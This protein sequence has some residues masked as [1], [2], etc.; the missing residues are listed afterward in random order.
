MG[1]APTKIHD[2][3]SKYGFL[4]P[5]H[6][7]QASKL[8]VYLLKHGVKVRYATR[9]FTYQGKTYDQGT[10]MVIR[11][12]N[13]Q[14]NW[15][16]ITNEACQKF[17]IQA[18]TVASGIMEKGA[19][20]GSP[21]IRIIHE[22]PKIALI[23][24]EQSSPTASGEIWHFFEQQ[25]DYPITLLNA[26]DLNR[27][28]LKDFQ[29]LIIPDGYYRNLTDKS[30]TEKLKAFVQS[31]GKI[32]ALESAA[33]QLA[34]ADWGFKNKE[35]KSEE[36]QDLSMLKKFGDQEKNALS[37][38][39]PGAIFKVELD[40]THPFCFGYSDDYFTLKQDTHLFEYLKDGWNIG[41]LKQDAYTAGFIGSQIRNKL[42]DGLL[43]GVARW[44]V[45]HWFCWP[46]T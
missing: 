32:I 12:S 26:S 9:P 18:D 24:G 5:Y 44:A 11:T 2:V 40:H 43:F 13:T 35:E 38:A 28:N 45:G 4:I 7:L 39:I 27:C 30:T 36:K 20:F 10:L 41:T 17:H 6:S 3:S 1:M 46:M 22:A 16:G 23:S 21:D 37:N 25:L 15:A 29:V 14:V 19:D 8:L 31:G 42:K 34:G 33:V